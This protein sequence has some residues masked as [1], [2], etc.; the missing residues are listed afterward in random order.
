MGEG[1][2]VSVRFEDQ[3]N[4]V[5]LYRALRKVVPHVVLTLT[6]EQGYRYNLQTKDRGLVTQALH[7][8]EDVKGDLG[9]ATYDL[10][11]TT[12][13]D[14]F[15][16]LV[17]D[18]NGE[19]DTVVESR[20]RHSELLLS[21]GVQPSAWKQAATIFTKRALIARRSWLMPLLAMA[22]AIGGTIWPTRYLS[23]GVASCSPAFPL[24]YSD[25]PLYPPR[26][27]SG[28]IFG[29]PLSLDSVIN[30]TL[31]DFYYWQ[32]QNSYNPKPMVVF[33]AD[34]ETLINSIKDGRGDY[35]I[36]QGGLYMDFD[37][38]EFVVVLTPGVSFLQL[39]NAATNLFYVRASN[40]SS[41]SGVNSRIL[42]TYR[43]FFQLKAET[44][45]SLQWLAIFGAAMVSICS[46]YQ[47]V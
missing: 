24:P 35:S 44:L 7:L 38:N 27:F 9:I 4:S 19:E 39:F 32:Y 26:L 14:I 43:P 45:F 13:E 20:T 34:R 5:L 47:S 16:E 29:G 3:D 22:V 42:T 15:L 12:I 46:Y 21:N 30:Q 6:N 23:G 40:S 10:C 37:K 36:S 2:S 41:A 25:L 31:P 17:A 1:Y 28:Q 11:G 18:P 33:V 8:I